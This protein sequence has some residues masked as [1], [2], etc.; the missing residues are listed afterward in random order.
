MVLGSL[1]YGFIQCPQHHD[2]C[3]RHYC[4][5]C[6]QIRKLNAS[7]AK[8]G[9]CQHFSAS[10][11]FRKE[12]YLLAADYLCSITVF[13]FSIR[14][15]HFGNS[16]FSNVGMISFHLSNKGRM[17]DSFCLFLVLSFRLK[18]IALVNNLL[19]HVYFFPAL[20]QISFST[21]SSKT[22]IFLDST[23]DP[24][25]NKIKQKIKKHSIKELLKI[26]K[27]LC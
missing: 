13:I 18:K 17:T 16:A 9:N 7:K 3:T 27:I 26:L 8:L 15:G 21:I 23:Q 20:S 5:C 22:Q 1:L 25:P 14:R 10:R 11:L 6:L 2:T 12:I 4:H 19:F 24:V